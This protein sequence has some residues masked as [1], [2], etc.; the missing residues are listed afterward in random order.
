MNYSFIR[1]HVTRPSFALVFVAIVLV[2]GVI[3]SNI[4]Q[5]PFVFD[6]IHSIVENQAIRDVSNFLDLKQL[7]KPR[8]VVDMTFA[9][10]YKFGKLDVFGYHL[11]NVL[12]HIINGF[13]VYF[14]ALTIF[15]QLA[16]AP[17]SL[18]PSIPQS[19]NPSIG[20]MSLFAA[21]IFVAHPI[22]TQA[23]T[24][25]VQRYASLAALFYM[26]SVL[27]YVKAKIVAQS[28]KLKP[29]SLASHP[30][31]AF[32]LQPSAFFTLSLLCGILA[33]M[34]KQNTASLPGAII[35]VE[36]MC[37]GGAWR[38]RARRFLWVI[39]A[40]VLFVG[41]VLYNMGLFGGAGIG[42]MLEDVSELARETELVG[43]Y[44]CTQF[45]VLV[46][47]IRLLFL[48]IGQNLDY[49][50]P[51]KTGFFD[52]YTPF[53]F[54]FLV[55]LAGLA[56]W[57]RNRRPVITFGMFWFFITLS[58]ESSII[59][60][61][62]A[63]FE[64]RLY[65][66]MFGFALLAAWLPFR[67][68]PKKRA[69]AVLIC[70][71]IV[72][73]LGT[74]TY[75]R[76]RI[77]QDGVTLWTDVL[78]KSP[79]NPRAC[80][81][82]GKAFALGERYDDAIRCYNSLLKSDPD[83]FKANNNMGIALG[84]RG[85][86]DGAI[87]C[88]R[89]ALRVAPD[90]DRAHYNL[91]NILD[92]RGDLEGA[93]RHY[94]E[95]LRIKPG[96]ATVHNNLG[97]VLSR[98]GDVESAFEHLREAVRI[99]PENAEALNNLGGV[100]EM[101]G[102]L[103]NAARHYSEALVIRRDYADAYVNLLRVLGRVENRTLAVRCYREVLRSDSENMDVH[104]NLGIALSRLDDLKGAVE[105]FSEAV[106]INPQD[107]RAHYN[108][109]L[110]FSRQ[111]RM[112]EAAE[113]YLESLRIRPQN[114]RVHYN[115]ALVL[116]RKGDFNGAINHFEEAMRLDPRLKAQ[117]SY[118]I[119]RAYARQGEKEKSERWLRKAVE[120]GFNNWNG[121]EA[122]TD[123][124]SIRDTLYYRKIMEKMDK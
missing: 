87:R 105:H 8:S 17:Q 52:A 19:L 113:Q 118:N 123:L 66:P 33:F 53:A 92:S 23:V 59:P 34:S 29:Q 74:A 43:S 11:V 1:K 119:A 97:V 26:G 12:L 28:S 60:I 79:R 14:L 42:S 110:A 24:Y 9:L 2:A 27:F 96:N 61:K 98:L 80:L 56:V 89:E 84:K 63:L 101:K 111:G 104:M 103:E 20:L 21:L 107:A 114:P 4:Y 48:P 100:L 85:D 94:S 71:S 91:G 47:Y 39:P 6:D 90:C 72:I 93:A 25:I 81:N 64:H 106:R 22:Q 120:A 82:L 69:L 37:F 73:S 99:D 117:A 58:V 38:E 88:Y 16:N 54:L 13:L 116:H 15:K 32:S 78:A 7:L 109:G 62:D 45:S 10:N 70:V 57:N 124:E 102:D 86:T 3:Y 36:C 44:L 30:F 83:N 49:L 77:W 67:L 40:F 5:S 50:Y 65:L 35:L 76:N 41:F 122:D 75:L 55:G 108:L 68:L 51:F 115:L 95:A 46:I 112:D 121:L 31:S 18:N